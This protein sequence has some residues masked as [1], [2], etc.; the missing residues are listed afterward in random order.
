MPIQAVVFD[1]G[2]VLVTT[3]VDRYLS[4][5]RLAGMQHLLSRA[6]WDADGVRDDIRSYVSGQLGDPGGMLVVDGVRDEA[7]TGP[8]DDHPRPGCRDSR[9]LGSWG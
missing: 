3:A 8:A 1:I 2:G 7:G 5:E 4:L 6:C 9:R